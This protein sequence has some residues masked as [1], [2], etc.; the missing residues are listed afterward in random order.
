M[1]LV[2]HRAERADVLADVLA[3]VRAELGVDGL[4]R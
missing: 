1:T 4:A 2:L 3:E